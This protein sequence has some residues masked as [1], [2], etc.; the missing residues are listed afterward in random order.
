[1]EQ[2]RMVKNGGRR[3]G[4]PFLKKVK[5][6]IAYLYQHSDGSFHV[7]N[8]RAPLKQL[9]DQWATALRYDNIVCRWSVKKKI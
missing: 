7:V 3:F 2:E 4:D 5:M 1:M 9:Q 6:I 8:M